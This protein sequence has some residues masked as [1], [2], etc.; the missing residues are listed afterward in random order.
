MEFEIG[1]ACGECDTYSPMGTKEC[2]ACGQDLVLRAQGGTVSEADEREFSQHG[3][4]SE[5]SAEIVSEVKQLSEEELMELARNYICRECSMGVPSGHKFCGTCG[6]AIPP[7]IVELQT[8]YFGTLQTPGKARLVLIRGDADTEGLSYVLQG[9]EHIAGREEGQILFPEDPWL[10]PR[11]ANFVYEKEQLLVRDE[12]S[13]NGVYVRIRE[14]I[15]LEFGDQFLCGEQLF[16]VE[17]PPED[18]AGP[19]P[20]QTYFYSSPRR[21]VNFVLVQVLQGGVAGSVYCAFEQ[22]L[23]I[24]RED[25]DVSYPLDVFMSGQH[26]TVEMTGDGALKLSDT[27]SRNGTYVRVKQHYALQHGDYLF[28]GKQL[29]RVEMTV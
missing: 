17:A 28:L 21:S 12:G 22:S 11:H 9:A 13:I 16:R 29:L 8:K 23:R 15:G 5:Q 25:C 20:D 26:A 10:S 7:E 4:L 14:P 27:G 24:G 3:S 2:P 18:S 19:D 6:A 1:I